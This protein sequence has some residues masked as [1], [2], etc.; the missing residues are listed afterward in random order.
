MVDIK[1]DISILAVPIRCSLT[2]EILGVFEVINTR[3]IEGM[4]ITG[5]STLGIRDYEI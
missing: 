4:S 1:T 5:S 3:G 2:K